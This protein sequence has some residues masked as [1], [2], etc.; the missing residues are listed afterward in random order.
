MY[1]II[2]GIRRQ[3]ERHTYTICCLTIDTIVYFFLFSPPSSG[4]L[5]SFDCFSHIRQLNIRWSQ[6]KKPQ[7]DESMDAPGDRRPFFAETFFFPLYYLKGKK[8]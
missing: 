1:L 3:K 8:V 4:L 6:R 7:M 5:Q 2:I